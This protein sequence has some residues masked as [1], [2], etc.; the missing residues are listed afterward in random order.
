METFK[1]E[2][3]FLEEKEIDRLKTI[4]CAQLTLHKSAIN[5]KKQDAELVTARM[6]FSN[7]LM[8][9][10]EIPISKMSQFVKK[11]RTAFYHYKKTHLQAIEVP[12]FYKEYLRDY[13]ICREEFI[14]Q[15]HTKVK[16]WQIMIEKL[17][18]NYK[19][20]DKKLN[21]IQQEINNFVDSE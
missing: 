17:S 19:K 10:L 2:Q 3:K 9:D 12:K 20:L 6:I 1:K 4:V 8:F 16:K 14:N 21:M 18:Y 7:I 15:T 13:E 11:D 5:S